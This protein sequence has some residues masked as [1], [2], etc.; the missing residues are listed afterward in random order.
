MEILRRALDD[1]QFAVASIQDEN[2]LV[3]APPGS[4]KTRVLVNAA[5]HRLRQR[6]YS[7]TRVMCLTFSTE[8]AREMRR[9]LNDPRL[10]APAARSSISNY[11]Q[12]SA[13]LLRSHGHLLG[14]PRDAGLLVPPD[15]LRLIEQV[16]RDL[17][18]H[19]N[20]R[21]VA[22]AIS[23][24]KGRRTGAGPLPAATLQKIRERYDHEL[25]HR[26]LRDFDDLVIDATQLLRTTPALRTLLHDA[27][28]FVFIDELQDTSLLQLDLLDELIGDNTRVFAV[29]DDDQMIYGWRDAHPA[30]IAE[31]VERFDIREKVLTGNY[32]CPP[33]I[34]AAANAVI[35]ANQRRRADLMTSMVTTHEGEVLLGGAYGE[36]AQGKLVGR[37]VQ[38]ALDEG[39]PAG[40]IAVLAPVRFLFPPVYAALD[41]RRI[42]YVKLGSGELRAVPVVAVLG[43]CLMGLAGGTITEGDLADT[44]RWPGEPTID[45]DGIHKTVETTRRLPP[46]AMLPELLAALGLGSLRKPTRDARELRLLTRMVRR[47]IEDSEPASTDSLARTM[48][49]EW[50]RLEAAALHAE[51][52]VKVM[53]SYGAKGTEYDVVVLPFLNDRLVP[54]ERRGSTVDWEE[55][56]RLFY[57]AL[58]R[59]RRRVVLLRDLTQPN[60]SLL[61][62]L[63]E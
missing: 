48:L 29:A 38:Q 14:W 17:R 8:A 21:N 47:A 19:A 15:N 44:P 2:L 6:P 42:P 50:D 58:T 22:G 10:Q 25:H 53:T 36:D 16:L 24:L 31:F 62:L 43:L 3:L 32:R 51:K 26:Y 39:V 57:V 11:H 37:V 27:Y 28:P 34:V 30:N 9:R 7:T 56:R 63:T 12:L 41:D 52:A 1:E 33:R 60:S 61:E 55:A 4:G 20:A 13:S 35:V 18:I 5:T 45:L 49:L 23:N 54:Y 46:R 40:E 59:A